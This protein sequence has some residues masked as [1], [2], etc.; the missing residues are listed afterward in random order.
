MKKLVIRIRDKT[1]RI[2]NNA[3]NIA[4]FQEFRR[5]RGKHY[6]EFFLL[7]FLLVDLFDGL[8][9]VES[10]EVFRRRILVES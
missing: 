2:H 3:V 5:I 6:L 1:S 7:V 9:I 8:M 4:R 10:F